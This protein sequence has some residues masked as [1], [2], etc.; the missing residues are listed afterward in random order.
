[1][2]ANRIPLIFLGVIVLIAVN[3]VMQVWWRSPKAPSGE[4]WTVTR[5][6]TGQTV[7][8]KSNAG[9]TTRIRLL[10][11]AAPWKEQEPWG[12]LARQRLEQLVKDQPVVLEF[13][14][15]QKERGD[16]LQ[17]YIWQGNTL[18]NAQL[19]KE[20]YVL[21]DV[22]PPNVKY[23]NKLKMLESEARLLEL[24]VWNPQDPMRI[25]PRD[26]RRQVLR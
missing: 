20:G 6:L 13:D 18:V 15:E 4:I 21:A 22:F 16:R 17:A 1:M 24:G 9:I 12:N 3:L 10:G 5:V 19:V 8:A 7:A 26:F 25:S 2:M 14:Q 11:I 23:E